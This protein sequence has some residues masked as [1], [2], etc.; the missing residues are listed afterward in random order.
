MESK[1]LFFSIHKLTTT[2]LS[3]MGMPGIPSHSAGSLIYDSLELISTMSVISETFKDTAFS[4]WMHL[5]G[6]VVASIW[7]SNSKFF[8]CQH[9]VTYDISFKYAQYELL[10][11]V[12][13]HRNLL[14]H[15]VIMVLHL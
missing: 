4:N 6:S 5:L 2:R 12:L 3:L 10:A 13:L 7:H 15:C 11:K 14:L 9:L 8:Y 1:L